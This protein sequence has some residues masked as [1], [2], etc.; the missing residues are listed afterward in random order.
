MAAPG[1]SVAEYYTWATA[2]TSRKVVAIVVVV[3]SVLIFVR[4]GYLKCGHGVPAASSTVS[5]MCDELQLDCTLTDVA[6]SGESSYQWEFDAY[7]IVHRYRGT[8]PD[9]QADTRRIAQAMA[10]ELAKQSPGKELRFN[11]SPRGQ[12]GPEVGWICCPECRPWKSADGS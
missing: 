10:N 9:I 8:D 5:R 6:V 3:V 12:G 2:S 7:H 4:A 11:I 1:G